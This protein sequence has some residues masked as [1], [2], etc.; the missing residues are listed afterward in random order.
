MGQLMYGAGLRLMECLR[1]RIKDIAFD[2]GQIVIR[3]GK[4]NKDRVTVLPVAAREGLRQQI[5]AVRH[6]HGQ[7]L[8][9]GHGRV[10]LPHALSAK[11]PN[12]D[13]EF[14]WQYL[15]PAHKLSRDPRTGTTRRHHLHE[16]FF[17]LALK[18]AARSAQIERPV[19]SHV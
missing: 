1:L 7:D 16:S 17:A 9:A 19:T 15:F 11:Y 13:R 4:G 3:E 10:W 18:R 2:L 8:E 5:Q 6:L 14:G 12:A